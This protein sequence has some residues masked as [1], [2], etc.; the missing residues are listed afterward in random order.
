MYMYTC[1]S[2]PVVLS[3]FVGV[4][5][6]LKNETLTPSSPS[7]LNEGSQVSVGSSVCSYSSPTT[8]LKNVIAKVSFTTHVHVRVHVHERRNTCIHIHASIHLHVHV[9]GKANTHIHSKTVNYG[10][11]ALELPWM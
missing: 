7:Y 8:V 11:N 1:I 3:S 2:K 4:K 6:Q 5:V 10:E 9:Y